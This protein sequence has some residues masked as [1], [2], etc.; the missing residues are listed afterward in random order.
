MKRTVILSTYTVFAQSAP[1]ALLIPFVSHELLSL[2]RPDEPVHK[3]DSPFN[4]Q[5]TLDLAW[6]RHSLFTQKLLRYFLERGDTFHCSSNK[7]G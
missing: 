5:C 6:S 4:A 1:Q 3:K 2:V 7:T